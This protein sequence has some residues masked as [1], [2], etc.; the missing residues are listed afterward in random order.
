MKYQGS[1]LIDDEQSSLKKNS[2]C[3]GLIVF[4]WVHGIMKRNTDLFCFSGCS[5]LVPT[6]ESI[7]STQLIPE[8][9]L[10]A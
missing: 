1:S 2:A 10:S 3:G 4:S 9:F 5:L 6:A 8:G 7:L